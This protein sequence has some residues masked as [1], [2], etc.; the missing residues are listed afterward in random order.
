M[1]LENE[2]KFSRS[3]RLGNNAPDFQ[4]D[5]YDEGYI[6]AISDYGIWKDG[7]QVIG[8]METPVR[9]VVSFIENINNAE[10]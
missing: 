5:C 8:C 9:E 6:Q 7:T 2:Y 1:S 10:L 4:K 3:S